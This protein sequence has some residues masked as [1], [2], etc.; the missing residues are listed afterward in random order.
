MST[1]Q[2]LPVRVERNGTGIKGDCSGDGPSVPPHTVAANA[3]GTHQPAPRVTLIRNPNL[4]LRWHPNAVRA[5]VYAR[6]PARTALR[7]LSAVDDGELFVVGP[8]AGGL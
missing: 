4:Q 3:R 2:P 8:G 5:C 6:Q 7:R 1:L